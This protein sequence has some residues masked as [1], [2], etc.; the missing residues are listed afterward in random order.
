[1]TIE[2]AKA[3]PLN[4]CVGYLAQLYEDCEC[5]VEC[6]PEAYCNWKMTDKEMQI[7]AD[8]KKAQCIRHGEYNNC[9]TRIIMQRV[10]D[11]VNTSKEQNDD[12]DI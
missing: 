7:R 2:E 12:K 9:P 5:I 10:L 6:F 3:L 8:K 11:C 4:E 1:M